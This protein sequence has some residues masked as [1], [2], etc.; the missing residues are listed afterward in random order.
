MIST[1]AGDPGSG[2]KIAPISHRMG[3]MI[4]SQP[5]TVCAFLKVRV[6]TV[7]IKVAG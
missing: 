7:K 3:K 4:P 1:A 5:N 2:G 6:A